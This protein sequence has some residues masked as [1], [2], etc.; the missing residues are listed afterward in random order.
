MSHEEKIVYD[1]IND[2]KDKYGRY[3]KCIFHMH[4]PASYDYKLFEDGTYYYDSVTDEEIFKIAQEVNLI[5]NE[6]QIELL[7]TYDEILYD[8]LKEYV[9]FLIIA[10]KLIDNGIEAVLIA[11]HNTFNGYEKLKDSIKKVYKSSDKCYPEVLLGA[12][13]SCADRNHVVVIFNEKSYGIAKK[14]F[15]SILIDEK[16]GT[17]Y[18]SLQVIEETNKLNGY[19]YIAHINSSDVLKPNLFSGGYKKELFN[20]KNLKILGVSNKEE[21]T[22]IKNRIQAITKRDFDFILDNDSHGIDTLTRNT[23]WVKGSKISFST[24]KDIYKDYDI[25]IS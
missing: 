21:V 19:A 25:T 4:T 13:I 11:D 18:T 23:F 20:N 2:R 5:A 1:L 10:K 22:I 16:S 17:Y 9:V 6:Q 8:S 24:I 12:E 3:H 7:C 15:D 14:F